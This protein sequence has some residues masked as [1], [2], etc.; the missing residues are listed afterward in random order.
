MGNNFKGFN[1]Y[2]VSI[3]AALSYIR[4][5]SRFTLSRAKD[6][7]V[8]STTKSTFR[9][10][11]SFRSSYIP[12]N[13]RPTGC[14]WSSTTSMS[15]SLSSRCSPRA[16]E[17]KSQAFT[18]GCVLKY[19]AICLLMVVV[20]VLIRYIRRG[21]DKKKKRKFQIFR[22]KFAFWAQLTML[23]LCQRVIPWHNV[24]GYYHTRKLV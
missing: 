8:R 4:I 22:Q 19:S 21:K 24:E 10:S 6:A 5:L 17:P 15:T 16:K 18:T 11:I 9:P 12:K 2:F 20:S 7:S 14:E 1:N 3:Y 13:L 23:S